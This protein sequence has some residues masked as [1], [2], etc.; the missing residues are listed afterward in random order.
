[1]A[2]VYLGL[3]I[4]E[5]RELVYQLES[6][7]LKLMST[8]IRVPLSLAGPFG[9]SV[10]FFLFLVG[11]VSIKILNRSRYPFL[12]LITTRTKN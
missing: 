1:M 3:V 9:S 10:G 6:L 11:A 12:T 5:F 7:G 8:S 2:V 4:L